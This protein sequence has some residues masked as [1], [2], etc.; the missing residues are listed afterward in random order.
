MANIT[1][2]TIKIFL[3]QNIVCRF[4]VPRE[5]VLDNAKNFDNGTVKEFCQSMGIKMDFV[6]VYHPQSNGAVEN[7]NGQIFRAIK[8]ILLDQK[9]GKWAEEL[10]GVVWSHNTTEYRATKFPPF[11]LLYGEEAVTPEE[12]K[13]GSLRTS[14]KAKH[15]SPEV[16][17]DLVDVDRLE[18]V[19]NLE[20]YQQEIRKWGDK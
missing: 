7:A 9:K 10:P 5:L 16:T 19:M 15:D 4:G 1:T 2:P 18:A 12:I 17:K 14:E 3:W 13:N 8:K 6:S 20:K 11:R